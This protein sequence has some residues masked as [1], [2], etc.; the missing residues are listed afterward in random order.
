MSRTPLTESEVYDIAVTLEDY[1]K[2]F[3]TFWEMSNAYFTDEIP[4]AAVQFNSYYKPDLLLNPD[5]W[6]SKDL[7]NQQFIISHECMHVILDHG[8]RNGK[9][10]KGAT[11][12]KVN[13]AQ[14]IAINEML[15]DLFGFNRDLIH[16]WQNF[17][18]IDTCF[19]DPTKVLKNQTYIYYLKLL[20]D[21]DRPESELPDLVDSHDSGSGDQSDQPDQSAGQQP[22]D[23]E[24][25]KI[26]VAKTLAEDLDPQDLQKILKSLPH[27]EGAGDLAGH[28]EAIIAKKIERVKIKFTTIIS[29]LKRS[30]FKRS[31]VDE[32]TFIRENRRLS[33]AISKTG[34]VLPGKGELERIKKDRLLTVLFMDISGSCI[35]YFPQFQK[36]YAAFD[37]EKEI[38][39]TKPYAFDTVV[40]EIQPGSRFGGFGGTNFHI[41]EEQ[42]L[43][44][45]AEIG[46]YPDCVI[47]IS[48][49]DAKKFTV[50]KPKQWVWLLTPEPVTSSIPQASRKILIKDV[51][52]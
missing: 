49:G 25:A 15:R 26:D 33:D 30:R 52:I 50:K 14:D 27:V 36:I 28:I 43:K 5:F 13:I 51:I 32:D 4:T 16:D 12:K 23:D 2:V 41:L 35:D 31:S 20:I 45:E 47:V 42:C 10:I 18:W 21:E 22:S 40:H 37:A 39:E 24:K 9:N 11:P 7:L 3:Y 38:F 1:H 29:K 44:L 34:V 48:D 46:R 8:V 19:K 6:K 17:C